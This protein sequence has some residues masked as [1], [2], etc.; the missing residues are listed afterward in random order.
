MNVNQRKEKGNKD[1]D[2]ARESNLSTNL[3]GI[4]LFCTKARCFPLIKNNL[5]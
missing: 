1:G 4:L 3:N 5:D 2:T